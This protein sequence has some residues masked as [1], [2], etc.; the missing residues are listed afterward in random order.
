MDGIVNAD[1]E[2]QGRDHHGQHVP[3]EADERHRPHD[4]KGSDTDG[5][6]DD[7]GGHD[8][9][10]EQEQDE[11]RDDERD[12]RAFDLRGRQTVQHRLEHHQITGDVEHG[13]IFEL[14]LQGPGI[15]GGTQNTD[16]IVHH[17]AGLNGR[18]GFD[19]NLVA[20]VNDGGALKMHRLTDALTPRFTRQR[21]G[22]AFVG[23]KSKEERA[24]INGVGTLDGVDFAG[25][26]LH[27]VVDTQALVAQ[28]GVP[29]QRV[30]TLVGGGGNSEVGPHNV[31][32]GLEVKVEIP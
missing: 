7:D 14:V 9:A 13:V 27:V 10:C 16:E 5:E 30:G 2:R 11:E 1:A 18:R 20:K 26:D 21:V 15:L 29:N 28:D 12:G 19:A 22:H 4:P 25:K 8:A 32:V 23:G 3:L 17:T 24:Q 6:Q 31:V